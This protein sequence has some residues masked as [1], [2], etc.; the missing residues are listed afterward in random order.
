MRGVSAWTPA[1]ANLAWCCAGRASL[2]VAIFVV[3]GDLAKPKSGFGFSRAALYKCIVRRAPVGVLRAIGALR[4][5]L[6]DRS[7]VP[8][9]DNGFAPLGD[10][11][12]LN[13]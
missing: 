8:G 1:P 6:G 9:D 2:I 4:G 13:A 12:P 10:A 11:K 7:A 3:L 5:D